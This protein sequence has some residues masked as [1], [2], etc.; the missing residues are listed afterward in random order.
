[1]HAFSILITVEM[2]RVKIF[3]VTNVEMA[4]RVDDMM[5]ATAT[6]VVVSS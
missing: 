4:K 5:Y 2:N 3:S 1:M 6:A